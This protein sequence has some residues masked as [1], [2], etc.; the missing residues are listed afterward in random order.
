MVL[1]IQ[2]IYNLPEDSVVTVHDVHGVYE[3]EGVVGAVNSNSLVFVA[4]GTVTVT[5]ADPA[6]NVSAQRTF[7]VAP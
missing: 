3:Q 4:P 5:V 2:E 1:E 7:L 6:N